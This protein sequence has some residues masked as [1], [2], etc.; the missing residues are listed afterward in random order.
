MGKRNVRRNSEVHKKMMRGE[1]I[2]AYRP[3]VAEP[4]V[5]YRVAGFDS[6][7]LVLE[8]AD[9]L[10]RLRSIAPTMCWND[11][12][13]EIG[14]FDAALEEADNALGNPAI[15]RIRNAQGRLL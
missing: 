9:A 13:P 11:D 12:H 3:M 10:H 6:A 4:S 7:G 8:L 2:P 15:H 1:S 14:E 5:P